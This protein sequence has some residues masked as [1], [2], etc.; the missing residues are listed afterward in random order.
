MMQFE[1]KEEFKVPH[2]AFELDE[3][4]KQASNPLIMVGHINESDIFAIGPGTYESAA[5]DAESVPRAQELLELEMDEDTLIED[6][7]D[8]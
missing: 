8:V 4:R 3:K 7:G 6:F 5:V 2:D 1:L